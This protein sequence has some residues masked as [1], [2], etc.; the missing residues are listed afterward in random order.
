MRRSMVSP[1]IGHYM[2]SG[3]IKNNNDTR[4][5]SSI[6]NFWVMRKEDE[7]VIPH[8]EKEE[9]NP[10]VNVACIFSNL[11]IVCQMLKFLHFKYVRFWGLQNFQGCI[12]L[13]TLWTLFFFLVVYSSCKSCWWFEA[14]HY[15][16]WS[17]FGWNSR[18]FDFN[19]SQKASKTYVCH[20]SS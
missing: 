4:C 11:T 13:V 12:R 18:G 3:P 7:Y 2:H 19:K 17:K 15:L 14:L 10:I 8:T 9:R 16:H 6:L 5:E 1:W 20:E